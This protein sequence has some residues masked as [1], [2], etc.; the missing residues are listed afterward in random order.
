MIGPEIEERNEALVS[1]DI[2]AL[3]YGEKFHNYLIGVNVR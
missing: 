1:K 3:N 2:D